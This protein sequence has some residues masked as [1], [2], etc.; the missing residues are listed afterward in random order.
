MKNYIQPGKTIT[1]IAPKNVAAGEGFFIG[2]LFHV[3]CAAALS[4]DDVE[5]MTEGLFSLPKTTKAGTGFSAGDRA[6]YDVSAE[7]FDA[8]ANDAADKCAGIAVEDADDDADEIKVKINVGV[9]AGVVRAVGGV[10]T[11]T[12]DD[13]T[14]NVALIDTGLSTILGFSVLLTTS[15]NVA[16]G[17][18]AVITK[19]GGNIS[20]A[21]GASTYDCTAGFK[22]TWTA[23][24]Y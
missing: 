16:N 19:S 11:Q 24:G 7:A 1:V 23:V 15:G 20:I 18:D 14:A 4:G 8:T 5:A 13:D 22:V 9:G 3:A 21:D 12:S 17:G 6:V 2:P 10:Y